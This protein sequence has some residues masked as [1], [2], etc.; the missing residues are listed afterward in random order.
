MQWTKIEDFSNQFQFNNGN[1]FKEDREIVLQ[2]FRGLESFTVNI[3]A[4]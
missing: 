1:E 4:L 3:S 2:I